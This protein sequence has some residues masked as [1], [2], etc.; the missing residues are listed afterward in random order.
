M[1]QQ[2]EQQRIQDALRAAAELQ[3][4][5]GLHSSSAHTTEAYAAAC[6]GLPS[7]ADHGIHH[8]WH[9]KDHS[10]PP[11]SQQIDRH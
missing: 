9:H 1:L 10:I 8:A 5:G 6:S 2:P 7:V 11:H 4:N 3:R